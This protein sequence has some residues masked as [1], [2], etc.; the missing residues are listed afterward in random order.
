MDGVRAQSKI[1]RGMGKAAQR[2]G[3]PFDVYRPSD[4][5]DPLAT[6]N[7]VVTALP[8]HFTSDGGYTKPNTYG[9]A[10]WQLMADG[11]QVVVGDYLTGQGGPYFIAAKQPLLPI[12]AVGC[13]RTVSLTQGGTS[14]VAVSWPASVLQAGSRGAN[15]DEYIPGAPPN[16]SWRM[17]LPAVPGLTFDVA[18]LV[19]DD[20]LRS[21][22]VDS[23]EL[24][25]LGWRITMHQATKLTDSIVNQYA[26]LIGL[27]GK[28]ITFRRVTRTG[29]ANPTTTNT[30]YSVK[31][32]VAAY[33]NEL[34]DGTLVKVGDLRVI[35]GKTTTAG[36]ALP[37]GPAATD[38]IG[39]DGAFRPVG[40]SKPLYAGS[41][42]AV[43]DVQA[44]G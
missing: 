19:T 40:V 29:G 25:D 34:V 31:A 20:L 14:P 35:M 41:T 18:D 24:T 5:T 10:T 6:G 28:T 12:L 21:Y 32:I 15:G 22:F 36:A 11:A 44:K 4:A 39:I 17:L 23:A 1:Y 9:A 33:A 37:A 26:L 13:N 3:L 42:V 27:I 8:A 38:F 16:P 43:Y 7:K 2:I 30:D